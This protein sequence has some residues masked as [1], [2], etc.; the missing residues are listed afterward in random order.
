M[1]MRWYYLFPSPFESNSEEG[2]D[3][4]IWWTPT[5]HFNMFQSWRPF[6]WPNSYLHVDRRKWRMITWV[7]SGIGSMGESH[8][9]N[10]INGSSVFG[11]GPMSGERRHPISMTGM[12]LSSFLNTWNTR[13]FRVMKNGISR[14]GHYHN[15]IE[16]REKKNRV[17]LI[18]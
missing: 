12:P 13:S 10:L 11:R 18:Q 8:V 5:R 3:E 1:T 16:P 9:F 7:E 2:D 4:D 6:W 17:S 14:G 15:F